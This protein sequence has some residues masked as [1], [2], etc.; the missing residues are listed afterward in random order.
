[1]GVGLKS[2]RGHGQYDRPRSK[3]HQNGRIRKNCRRT[4]FESRDHREESRVERVAVVVYT[5]RVDIEH[6]YG[7]VGLYAEGFEGKDVGSRVYKSV[8]HTFFNLSASSPCPSVLGYK[9]TAWVAHE[10]YQGAT[11]AIRASFNLSERTCASSVGGPGLKRGEHIA[12]RSRFG[13][14]GFL[15]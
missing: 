1:M 5:C 13:T 14:A 9:K 6:P 2:N 11:Y 10:A 4:V 15:R 12:G 3:V 7:F 8:P